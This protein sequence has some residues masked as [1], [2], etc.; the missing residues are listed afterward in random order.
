MRKKEGDLYMSKDM[1][2]SDYIEI[3]TNGCDPIIYSPIYSD[4]YGLYLHNEDDKPIRYVTINDKYL[5]IY[6][7]DGEIKTI[8]DTIFNINVEES[9]FKRRMKTSIQGNLFHYT[10]SDALY[11]NLDVT[12]AFPDDV[13]KSYTRKR[14]I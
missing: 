2:F 8:N 13:M 5:T 12:K 11:Y 6:Y 9:R 7:V 4:E 10:I 1:I 3:F 14:S